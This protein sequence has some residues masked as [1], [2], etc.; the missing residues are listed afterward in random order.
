MTTDELRLKFLQEVP[1]FQ[2]IDN[3][4]FLAELAANLEE[5]IFPANYTIFTKGD[6]GNLLYL[7]VSGKVKVHQEGFTLA[8]FEPGDYFGEMALFESRSR[9]TSVT[10]LQDSKCLILTAE[11]VYQTI[12]QSPKI[13]L[14]VISVLAQRVRKLNRLF[15]ASEELFY[16]AIKQQNQKIYDAQ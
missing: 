12:K 13:A 11:Q 8:Y 16:L 7:L 2:E 1:I 4:G 3:Q 14:N 10:T 5:V 15:G 9:Q 6:D